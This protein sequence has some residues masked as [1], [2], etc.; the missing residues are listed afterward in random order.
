MKGLRKGLSMLGVYVLVLVAFGLFSGMIQSPAVE[1]TGATAPEPASRQPGFEVKPSEAPATKASDANLAPRG[2][3]GLLQVKPHI[4]ALVLATVTG[5]LLPALGMPPWLVSLIRSLAGS[6]GED[7]GGEK[8]KE[9]EDAE[10]SPD[11]N[12]SVEVVEL[13]SKLHMVKKSLAEWQTAARKVAQQRDTALLAQAQATRVASAWSAAVVELRGKL[14]RDYYFR[15]GFVM[16]LMFAF[17]AWQLLAGALEGGM[18]RWAGGV[19]D[20]LP[21]A[22]SWYLQSWLM[23]LGALGLS[24]LVAAKYQRVT[25]SRRP[26]STC[27]VGAAG[28]LAAGF[29][30]I[31]MVSP[32]MFQAMSPAGWDVPFFG[33]MI[34]LFYFLIIVRIILLPICGL[35][36]GALGFVFGQKG[37]DTTAPRNDAGQVGVQMELKAPAVAKPAA[38]PKTAETGSY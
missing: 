33:R 35:A 2:F 23:A 10:S 6:S 7:R 15:W 20:A 21:D 18:R 3:F 13:K 24:W 38:R 37:H 12:D 27:Y 22:I 32:Q 4:A 30:S 11:P 16:I 29:V 1:D 31:L 14:D 36:G 26:M 28:I 25:R 19:M 8:E 34:P 17:S 5:P 9:K